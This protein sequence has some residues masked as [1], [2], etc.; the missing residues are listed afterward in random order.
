MQAES[1]FVVIASPGKFEALSS[2]AMVGD[3]LP[4][5]SSF[6]DRAHDGNLWQ[7]LGAAGC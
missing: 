5:I 7:Q 3:I 4:R 6:L 2:G 1:E